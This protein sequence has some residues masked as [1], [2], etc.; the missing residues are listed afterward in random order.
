M[1]FHY[2]YEFDIHKINKFVKLKKF[3][4]LDFGCGIGNWSLNT[5]SSKQISKITLYDIDQELNKILRKKYDSK[6]VNINFKYKKITKIKDFN[7]IIFSSVIQYFSPL[8]LKRIIK[9]L[10]KSKKKVT[11]LIID[12]PF[13]PRIIEFFLLPLFNLRRFLFILSLLFSKNYKK[14]NYFTYSRK[15]FDFYKKKFR[16]KFIKNLHDLKILRH[17]LIM[18]PK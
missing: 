15:E 4:I 8:E 11:I 10:T 14:I 12:I 7:L 1:I 13:L 16:I 5:I 2:T 9:D 3:K 17:S 6:K 18:T